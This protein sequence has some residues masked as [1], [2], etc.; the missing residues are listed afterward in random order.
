MKKIFDV[1]GL[2]CVAVDEILFIEKYPHPDSK[3][4]ILSRAREC[5]GLT[6]TALVAA[7]RLGG[8]CAYAGVIGRDD[9]SNFTL[10]VLRK[11]GIHVGHVI[12]D[13]S[14]SVCRSMILVDS[15]QRRN[16]FYDISAVRGAHPQKPSAD[17]IR[18]GKVF[19]VD[20]LGVDGMI[21]A[22]TIARD[23]D[24]PVVADLERR[25]SIKLKKLWNLVDH[26]ILSHD[27]AMSVT[28]RKS[29]RQCVEK[30]ISPEKK[31]VV[32]T[33]GNR[34]CWFWSRETGR[35][36]SR[37]AFRVKVVDTTGC[38]DVFHGAY[39]LAL[40]RGLSMDQRIRMASAAAALKATRPGG[41]SGIPNLK[42]VQHFLKTNL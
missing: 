34:G 37:P 18:S 19:F 21:R 42:S 5:G 24:I 30:L 1:I 31:A 27:M 14:A 40:A 41:Q 17:F 36:E 2:G 16:I 8:R 3:V 38:G 28:G 22:A 32:V 10:N 33:E 15:H 26:L 4:Q 39:A 29:V 25:N 35:I 20:N 12:Q 13:S 7:A 9:A 23:A 11:E 6:A